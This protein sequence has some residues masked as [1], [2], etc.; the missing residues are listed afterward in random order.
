MEPLY[1]NNFDELI[2][3][4]WANFFAAFPNAPNYQGVAKEV[5][6]YGLVHMGGGK[7]EHGEA[8]ILYNP[9]T[10]QPF[11]MLVRSFTDKHSYRWVHPAYARRRTELIGCDKPTTELST[12]DI[13]EKWYETE[14]IEDIINKVEKILRGEDHDYKVVMVFDMDEEWIKYYD[15]LAAERGI[16]RD[17]LIEEALLKALKKVDKKAFPNGY[18]DSPV[19]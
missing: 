4:A 6:L 11:E 13:A 18:P 1:E 9:E 10:N 2:E 17:E 16:T 8:H 5:P 7:T 3:T 12:R 14:S 19:A 15:N